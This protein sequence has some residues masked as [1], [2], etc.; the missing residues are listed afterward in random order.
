MPGLGFSVHDGLRCLS[1]LGFG[2]HHA[3]TLT[4]PAREKPLH[5]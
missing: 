3:V 4:A 5:L 2:G 1:V